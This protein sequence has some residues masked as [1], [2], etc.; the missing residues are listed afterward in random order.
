VGKG[1]KWVVFRWG[2]TS[3]KCNDL[4]MERCV[5][6]NVKRAIKMRQDAGKMKG[7]RRKSKEIVFSLNILIGGQCVLRLG[8]K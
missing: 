6:R 2:G 7:E 4:N 5:Q 8:A 1:E 3:N